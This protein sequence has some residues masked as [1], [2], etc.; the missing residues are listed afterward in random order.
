VL[1]QITELW[2]EAEVGQRQGVRRPDIFQPQ[3]HESA[4]HT[5]EGGNSKVRDVQEERMSK[6]LDTVVRGLC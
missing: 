3:G 2:L 1:S 5:A 6:A 4:N